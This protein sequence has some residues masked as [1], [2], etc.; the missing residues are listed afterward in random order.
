MAKRPHK[1]DDPHAKRVK[2]ETAMEE[3]K[4]EGTAKEE[5]EEATEGGAQLVEASGEEDPAE[6]QVGLGSSSSQVGLGSSSS[7]GRRPPSDNFP[8]RMCQHGRGGCGH[9]TYVNKHYWGIKHGWCVH[10][11]GHIHSGSHT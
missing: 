8:F 3:I 4:E 10:C 2:E 1:S 9:R 11:N 6:E 7:R 5:I